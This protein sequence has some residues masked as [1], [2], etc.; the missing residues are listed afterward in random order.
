[1]KMK[2]P[3][4]FTES[5]NNE[6][7]YQWMR[8]KVDAAARLRELQST[9]V[10]LEL[11]LLRI[12]NQIEEASAHSRIN[13]MREVVAVREF[14]ADGEL[15]GKASITNTEVEFKDLPQS[16]QNLA[17]IITR[18]Y[19]NEAG[20][21]AFTKEASAVCRN[22]EEAFITLYQGVKQAHPCA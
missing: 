10:E 18:S 6:E 12:K 17:Q 13:I 3:I 9:K 20:T 4:I 1:M 14:G 21:S 15:A 8:K 11:S 7:V 19:L 5:F 16:I 22:V 2:E